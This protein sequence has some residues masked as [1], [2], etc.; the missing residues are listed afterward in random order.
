MIWVVV[1]AA[2]AVA[3]AAQ[4]VSGFGFALIATPLVAVLVGPE[5]AVIGLT[6]ASSALTALL[7]SRGRAAVDRP[8]VALITVA[9]A[10]GMPLGVVILA[11][12]GDRPLTIVIAVTVIAFAVV[13][14][15]GVRLPAGRMTKVVAGFGAGVLSTSTGTSGPPIVIALSTEAREPAAFRA[16]ISAIF[17]IQGAIAL[18]VFAVARRYSADAVRVAAA[19]LPGVAL[20]SIVG[21]RAF[22][23]LDAATFSRVVLAMLLAS[24]VIALGGALVG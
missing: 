20:G 15:R 1:F 4:A 5:E 7:W 22:R 14:W 16:T 3:A 6:I 24:G 2:I 11:S 13:L 10:C 17:L 19:G 21:E 9:A 18:G 12:T 23:R 8:T